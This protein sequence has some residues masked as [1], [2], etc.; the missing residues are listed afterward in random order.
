VGVG[1]ARRAWVRVAQAAPQRVE[2][3]EAADDAELAELE[4]RQVRLQR[5]VRNAKNTGARVVVSA[6]RR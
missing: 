5:G 4:A 1:A 3:A 6:Q 2:V